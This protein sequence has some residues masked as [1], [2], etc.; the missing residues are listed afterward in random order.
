MRVAEFKA[1]ARE[2]RLR[3]YSRMRRAQLIELIRNDQQN[4]N[5]P[6]QSWESSIIPQQPNR[7]PPPP[8]TRPPPTPR[9]GDPMGPPPGQSHTIATQT[10]DP[11]RVPGPLLVGRSMPSGP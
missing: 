6:L 9:S 3:G 1:L 11:R 7:P 10:W 4:T 2:R 5:T 8:P